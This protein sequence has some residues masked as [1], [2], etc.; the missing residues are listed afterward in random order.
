MAY[1]KTLAGAAL[2]FALLMLVSAAPASAVG[3]TTLCKANETPCSAFNHYGL[4]TEFRATA[5]GGI[6]LIRTGSFF[7]EQ[8]DCGESVIKGRQ[9]STGSNTTGVEA[10]VSSIAFF[11]CVLHSTKAGCTNRALS[12]LPG[13]TIANTAG[14]MNGT[15]SLSKFSLSSVCETS[16]ECAFTSSSISLEMTGG[17]PA[18]LV[19]SEEKLSGSGIGCPKAL[20]WTAIYTFAEPTALW[21]AQSL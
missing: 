9:I 2:T 4:G 16:A 1:F 11:A 6:T 10:E 7:N 19:A 12:P 13:A 15:F 21:L 14:T 20:D 17:E 5:S 18:S 3:G 8:I